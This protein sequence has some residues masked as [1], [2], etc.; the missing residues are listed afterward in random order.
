MRL[1]ELVNRL[2][3]MRAGHRARN[4]VIGVG[5]LLAVLIV[6]LLTVGVVGGGYLLATLIALVL[7]PLLTVGAVATNYRKSATRLARLPGVTP[8]G[9]PKAGLFAGLYVFVL[10]GLVVTAASGAIVG[11]APGDRNADPE[12]TETPND[13]EEFEDDEE[14]LSEEEALLL[15]ETVVDQSDAELAEVERANDELTVEYHPTATTERELLEQM[16]TISGAYVGSISDG[17]ATERMHVT[18]LDADGNQAF[19]WTVE[20]DW[21]EAYIDEEITMDEIADRALETAESADE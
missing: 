7:L 11:T 5:Y 14:T 6:L 18:A 8:R 4:R 1:V 13:P 3:G 2:P 10:W 12:P 20:T 19:H 17:L 21:A 9:G 15:F 16:G